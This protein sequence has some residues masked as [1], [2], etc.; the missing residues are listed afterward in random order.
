MDKAQEIAL[1]HA[2]V[3]AGDAY[4]FEAELDHDDGVTVYEIEFKSG[5]MEYEYKIDAYTG[6]ILEHE[7][8]I[9]D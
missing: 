8:E 6:A 9:D 5:N 2:G 3:K 1:N 4:E 7:A